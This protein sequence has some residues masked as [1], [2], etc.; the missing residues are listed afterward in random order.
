MACRPDGHPEPCSPLLQRLRAGFP[1]RPALL[2][3]LVLHQVNAW[4]GSSP[5]G[6]HCAGC[7]QAHAFC[8]TL[9]LGRSGVCV[10]QWLCS[11]CSACSRDLLSAGSSSG[12]HHDF[13]DNLYILLRGRKRFT[14]YPPSLAKRMAT[15]GCIAHVHPNG[16]VRYKGQVSYTLAAAW[17][18][19]SILLLAVYQALLQLL[20]SDACTQPAVLADGSLPHDVARWAEAQ[21]AAAE[22]LPP[23]QQPA[24]RQAAETA[25]DAALEATLPQVCAV[26]VACA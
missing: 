24:A 9:Y 8:L 19:I 26:G 22:E 25:L 16:R 3:N 13:H 11:S 7:V 6:P 23:A 1:L 15:Q 21:L 10:C 14:L 5:E 20:L 12:L 2:G 4:L 17:I 18:S